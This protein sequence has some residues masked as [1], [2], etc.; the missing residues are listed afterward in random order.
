VPEVAKKAMGHGVGAKRS[1]SGAISF[2]LLAKE[3][4]HAMVQ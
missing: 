3:E 4:S 2:D 1:K